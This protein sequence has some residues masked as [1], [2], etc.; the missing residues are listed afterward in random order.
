MAEFLTPID[1]GNRALQHCGAEMMDASLG[2][3]E[4]SKNARQV[5]F[6]YGKLRRYEE[7]GV[8]RSVFMLRAADAA[9]RDTTERKLDEWAERK[10]AYGQGERLSSR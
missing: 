8:T 6:A 4:P 1:I 9:A 10:A 3:T 7:A 5:S 2:F